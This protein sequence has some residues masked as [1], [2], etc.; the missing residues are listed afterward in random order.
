MHNKKAA[1]HFAGRPGFVIASG[2]RRR[3]FLGHTLGDRIQTERSPGYDLVDN[4]VAAVGQHGSVTPILDLL[5]EQERQIMQYFLSAEGDMPT[6]DDV[7]EAT[8]LPATLVRSK[9]ISAR[10]KLAHP[11]ANVRQQLSRAG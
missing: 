11:A 9:R 5:D 10:S 3:I 7:A 1:R 6:L 8:G 2:L 4:G